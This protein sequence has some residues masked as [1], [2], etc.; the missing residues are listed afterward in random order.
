MVM[1]IAS[2]IKMRKPKKKNQKSSILRVDISFQG[3]I[4]IYC[5]KIWKFGT[6]KLLLTTVKG[7]VRS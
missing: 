5:M 4:P 2:N 3:F 7:T 1:I 6:L